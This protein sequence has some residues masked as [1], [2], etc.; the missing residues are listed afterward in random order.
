MRARAAAAAS[1]GSSGGGSRALFI[2][3]AWLPWRAGQGRARRGVCQPDS[4]RVR[5]RPELGDDP[6][7]RAPLVDGLRERRPKRVGPGRKKV[8]GPA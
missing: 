2:G 6:D 4:A 1:K 8:N 5:A 3:A 7:M